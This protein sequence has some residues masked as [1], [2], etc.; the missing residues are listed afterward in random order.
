MYLPDIYALF[1]LSNRIVKDR[2]GDASI[3]L[4]FSQGETWTRALKYMLTNTKVK[5][6]N[7]SAIDY[8]PVTYP[9]ADSIVTS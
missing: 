5:K 7:A 6:Q 4:H 3:K 9:L 1:L 8:R 2:I